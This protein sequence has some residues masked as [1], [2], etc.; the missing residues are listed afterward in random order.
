ML[1]SPGACRPKPHRAYLW[2]IEAARGRE[3]TP[4]A[5]LI[6]SRMLCTRVSEGKEALHAHAS[7]WNWLSGLSRGAS[8]KRMCKISGAL[9]KGHIAFPRRSF[10]H[11]VVKRIRSSAVIKRS[12]RYGPHLVASFRARAVTRTCKNLAS[13]RTARVLQDSTCEEKLLRRLAGKKVSS[14]ASHA[15]SP[16]FSFTFSAFPVGRG[17]R[18]QFEVI[19]SRDVSCACKCVCTRLPSRKK[20]LAKRHLRRVGIE[21]AVGT[22][23][24]CDSVDQALTCRWVFACLS[25]ADALVLEANKTAS[26]IRSVS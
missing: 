17:A 11:H 26:S 21:V 25:P 23:V 6:S 9:G 15:S 8:E 12:S 14:A 22:W 24:V 5:W 2:A 1:T 20:R 13:L 16:E 4:S 3:D 18:L 7:G 19:H 10:Q